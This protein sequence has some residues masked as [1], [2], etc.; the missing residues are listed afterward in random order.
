MEIRG[1]RGSILDESI[2]RTPVSPGSQQEARKD[3][4]LPLLW[5]LGELI[6]LVLSCK[7]NF[8]PP[9]GCAQAQ[10]LLVLVLITPMMA[11]YL[12]NHNPFLTLLQKLAPLSF[13][14]T[15]IPHY[16]S[17]TEY[18]IVSRLFMLL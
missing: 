10:D 5:T 3:P 14:A 12:Q 18:F 6:T 16:S 17:H 9:T 8:P 4:R 15:K 13:P 1:T 2:L 7:E 11:G